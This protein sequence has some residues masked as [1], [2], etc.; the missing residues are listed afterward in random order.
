MIDT[1][2]EVVLVTGGTGAIGEALC[3][4]FGGRGAT[5]IANCHPDDIE[6]STTLVSALT[7]EGLSVALAPF[8]VTDHAQCQTAIADLEVRVGGITVLVNAAGITRDATLAKM[9]QDDWDA[10]LRTNLD[11]VYH[12]SKA[13]LPGMKARR[14]GRVISI[15]SVNGQRGQ[16]GQTNYAAAK[17]GMTGFTRSLAREVAHHGIT[18]NAVSPG[19][20]RSPM[21]DAVPADIRDRIV[22]DIPVG[23]AAEPWEIAHAIQFLADRN[24]GYITG[25]DLSVNGGY[26]IA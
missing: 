12:V 20:V 9:S 21:T 6:R 26:H 5:I 13:C 24:S 2:D 7:G 1:Q 18:V 4:G 11:S 17:A 23:R 15:S 19:Y 14:Y 22:A 10:V 16:F 8:D 3:R 25:V